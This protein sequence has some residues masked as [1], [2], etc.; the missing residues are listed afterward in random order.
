MA[1]NLVGCKW[2]RPVNGCRW[3]QGIQGKNLDFDLW[4]KSYN[5]AKVKCQRGYYSGTISL[6]K[7]FINQWQMS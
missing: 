7:K 5:V 3:M 1:E 4:F 2:V 6:N